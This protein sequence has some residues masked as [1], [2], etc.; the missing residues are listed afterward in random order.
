MGWRRW[1]GRTT[2]TPRLP[3]QRRQAAA[4][5]ASIAGPMGRRRPNARRS[6]RE[7]QK[8]PRHQCGFAGVEFRLHEEVQYGQ[9]SDDVDSAVDSLPPYAEAR[10]HRIGRG[11]CENGQAQKAREADG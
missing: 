9:G 1:R 2:R 11:R 4:T 7:G 8:Q 5:H 6:V 10:D 3:W